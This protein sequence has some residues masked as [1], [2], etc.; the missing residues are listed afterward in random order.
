M[1]KQKCISK[2]NGRNF[3]KY[4]KTTGKNSI[5]TP[6]QGRTRQVLLFGLFFFFKAG[7]HISL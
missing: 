3:G 2:E 6:G 4:D 5:F 1:G 7:F